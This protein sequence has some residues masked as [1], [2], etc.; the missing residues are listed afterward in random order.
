MLVSLKDQ[1]LVY[2]DISKPCWSWDINKII[3][4]EVSHDVVVVLVEEM[5]RLP[6][7]LQLGLH[8]ASCL[9]HCVKSS[10][11]D[12]LSM[13]FCTNLPVLLRLISEKGFLMHDSGDSSF[14]FVHDKIQQAAKELMSEQQRLELH[15]QLGLAICSSTLEIGQNDELFFMSVNQSKTSNLVW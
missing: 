9:G 11:I 3:D 10:V 7:Q 5:R 12:I 15:M 8:I 4:L 2:V 13:E 6:P 14:T 1:G